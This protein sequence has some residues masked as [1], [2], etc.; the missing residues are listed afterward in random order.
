[1]QKIPE[2]KKK[3]LVGGCFDVL[4]FGHIEFLKRAKEEGEFLIVALESDEF[5]KRR[6]NRNP[7]HN[8][9]E[10]AKIL[11]A[12]KYVDLVIKIPYLK[13]DEQYLELVKTIKPQIIAATEGDKQMENKKRQ[14][15]E[16][17]GLVQ[18]VTPVIKEFSSSKILN[19]N[20]SISS[21]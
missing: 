6:K 16:V 21:N 13:S 5:I 9:E 1:M 7:I 3:V 20:A 17:H 12:I 4:H 15:A 14:A 18:V 8:Q 10:R 19:N 11:E 2:N